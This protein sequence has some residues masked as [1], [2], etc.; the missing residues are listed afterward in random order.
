MGLIGCIKSHRSNKFNK[1]YNSYLGM[2]AI[3]VP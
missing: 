1:S 3:I 2:A